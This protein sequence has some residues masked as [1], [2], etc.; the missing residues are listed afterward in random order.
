[1]AAVA[2]RVTLQSPTWA[3]PAA[4]APPGQMPLLWST[5]WALLAGPPWVPMA[6]LAIQHHEAQTGKE[7]WKWYM[8]KLM[9]GVP[10]RPAL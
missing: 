6:A 2:E 5:L 1:M 3:P 8:Q 7:L 9:G 4:G 10:E